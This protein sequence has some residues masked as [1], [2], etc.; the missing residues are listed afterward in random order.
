[1]PPYNYSSGGA[2]AWLPN[3]HEGSFLHSWDENDLRYD[4]NLYSQYIGPDGHWVA[5]PAATPLSF[6]KFITDPTGLSIYSAP[7]FRYA[8]AFLILAE[9][10]SMANNGP[11][12]KALEHLN[13]IKRRGYGLDPFSPSDIDYPTGMNAEEFRATV[14]Q[15]RAY[16][17]IV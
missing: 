9:A 17:F 4:F 5:L 2:Y 10:E 13:I 6:A 8:E 7:I 11:N 14:L 12:A 15:E 3:Q 1:T 16:E